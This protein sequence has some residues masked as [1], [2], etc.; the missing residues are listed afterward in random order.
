M[1]GYLDT[2]SLAL[3]VLSGPNTLALEPSGGGRKGGGTLTLNMS[4]LIRDWIRGVSP[5]TINLR[6]QSRWAHNR[7]A[8]TNPT[9]RTN[10][11]HP[12]CLRSSDGGRDPGRRYPG[13]RT[14]RDDCG[15]VTGR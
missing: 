15:K 6:S 14:D 7:E 3:S 4:E 13:R 10:G 8:T 12:V 9:R 1:P 2:C 5:F 11:T